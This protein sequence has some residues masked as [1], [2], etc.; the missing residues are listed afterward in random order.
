MA[1]GLTAKDEYD[2]VEVGGL[3][4]LLSLVAFVYSLPLRV[5]A[6]YLP[7]HPYFY[8]SR[9]AYVLLSTFGLSLVG[10]LAAWLGRRSRRESLLCRW[11]L[12][13]N[14]SVLGIL[15]TA[16]IALTVWWRLVR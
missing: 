3:W 8:W 16:V 7:G 5:L 9:P 1:R 10:I 15:I 11:A 6:P 4:G 13:L 2:V 12:I 14:S